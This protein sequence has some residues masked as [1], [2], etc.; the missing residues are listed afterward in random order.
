MCMC[1]TEQSTNDFCL[2][3]CFLSNAFFENA[4]VGNKVDEIENSLKGFM[5]LEIWVVILSGFITFYTV[6]IP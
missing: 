3:L 2:F 1:P 6:M 5:E 4:A